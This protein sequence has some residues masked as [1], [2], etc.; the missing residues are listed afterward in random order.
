MNER[1]NDDFSCIP[2]NIQC[3]FTTLLLYDDSVYK[4]T[5]TKPWII[6]ISWLVVLWKPIRLLWL[7]KDEKSRRRFD[8]SSARAQDHRGGLSGVII[9]A[10]LPR[11][12]LPSRITCHFVPERVLSGFSPRFSSRFRLY[13]VVV[14]VVL[15]RRSANACAPEDGPRR[16]RWHQQKLQ[17]PFQAEYISTTTP[18]LYSC[19][20]LLL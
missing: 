16:A 14:V 3:K 15:R 11:R 5:R 7:W 20:A 13:L 9:T 2:L 18:T 8:D 10:E 12:H 19:I 6:Y 1:R 4:S 17:H